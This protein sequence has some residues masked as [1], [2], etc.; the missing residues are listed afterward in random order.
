MKYEIKPYG[1]FEVSEEIINNL[2]NSKAIQRLKKINQLGLPAKWHYGYEFSR[3]EHSLG[4]LYLSYF[5]NL[6]LNTKIA[7]ILHDVAHT[8]FSHVIDYL[9]KNHNE[10]YHDKNIKSYLIKDKEIISLLVE[11]NI[12]VNQ[13]Y[14]IDKNFKFIKREDRLLTLDRLDYTLREYYYMTNNT[15]EINEILNDLTIIDNKFVFKSKSHAKRF[16]QIYNHISETH[17]SAAKNRTR[18]VIFSRTL[19]RA[20]DLKLIT[21]DDFYKTDDY[22]LNILLKSNDSVIKKNI[23]KLE[24]GVFEIIPFET[25]V[26]KINVLYLNENKTIIQI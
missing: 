5:F 8:A 2:I 24:T 11:N 1:S 26:R 3:Y 20:L 4:V 25:K 19:K 22:I 6:D 12:S 23:E 14:E 16:I 9:L 15:K 21:L 17:W 13:F 18:Y 7:A 10:D